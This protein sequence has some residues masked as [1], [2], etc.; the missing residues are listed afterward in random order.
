VTIPLGQRFVR[1]VRH[2]QVGGLP[3]WLAAGRASGLPNLQ[4]FATG[5]ELDC[6]AIRAALQLPWSTGQVE[7]QVTKIKLLKRKVYGRAGFA[8]LPLRVLYIA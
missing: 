8:L 6:P 1:L 4:S 7:G 2:R 5:L 3:A